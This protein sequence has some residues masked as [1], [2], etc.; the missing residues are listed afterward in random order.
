MGLLEGKVGLVTGAGSGLGRTTACLFATEGARVVVTD[1]DA[2][3]GEE[4]AQQVVASGGEAVFLRT[5]VR[6]PA[7]VEAMVALAVQEYGRLDCASNNAA[8]SAS[9]SLTPDISLEQWNM[10]L[11]VTLTGVWLCMKYEIPAMLAAGAGS[12]VNISSASSVKGETMLAAYAAAK[13][14]VN[15]LTLTAAAEYATQGIRVN[16]VLPGGIRTPA[17]EH[18][19]ESMPDIR[20]RTVGA[21]AMNRLAE[22]EEIAQAVAWLASDRASFVTG[23][24]MH[25]DGG[26]LIKSHLL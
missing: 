13:G 25:A 6:E 17:I 9:Y 10:A 24:L 3:T 21:H 14:G 16:A 2:V 22:P 20:E 7:Q 15:T 8:A 1:R 11:S 4:T 19:F 12:I 23:H 5:D 26:V 18:Y